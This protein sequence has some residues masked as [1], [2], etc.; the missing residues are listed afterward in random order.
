MIDGNI[1]KS[2]HL[3]RVQ[4]DR[5]HAIRPRAL[6]QIGHQLGGDRRSAGMLLIL[7]GIS[8]IGNHRRHPLRA[9]P[10][11]RVDPDEQLHQVRIDRMTRRLHDVAIAPANV[12]LDADDQLAVRETAPSPRGQAESAN[13]R[14]FSAPAADSPG[15]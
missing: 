6:Q 12:F 2:L 10:A 3:R 11:K 7:P 9:G 14:R 1:E 8:E 5:H 4:I 15:R 13:S